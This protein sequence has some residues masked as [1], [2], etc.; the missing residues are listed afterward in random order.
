MSL[1]FAS[2]KNVKMRLDI[3]QA[4]IFY[5]ISIP[6]NF[7]WNCLKTIYY[8]RNM[9]NFFFIFLTILKESLKITRL[10]FNLSL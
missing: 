7:A 1:V 4:Q 2:D 6:E 10:I 9:L 3:Y 8:E 5:L